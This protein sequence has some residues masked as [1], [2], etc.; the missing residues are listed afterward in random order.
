[1]DLD[2]DGPIDIR[3]WVQETGYGIESGD[4]GMAFKI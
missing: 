2:M 4:F 3:T 1:M